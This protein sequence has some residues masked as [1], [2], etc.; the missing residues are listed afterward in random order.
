[1]QIRSITKA[2]ISQRV[3]EVHSVYSLSSL[4]YPWYLY[5]KY[6]LIYEIEVNVVFSYDNHYLSHLVEKTT[7]WFP[8]R[9]DTNRA[10]QA[11]KTARGWK[12][13]I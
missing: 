8:N 11:Q 2:H 3:R 13:W 5:L 7:M 4:L 12:F 9:S 6:L 1:M 10:A